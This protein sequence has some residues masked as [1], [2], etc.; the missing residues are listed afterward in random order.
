MGQAGQD[1][2]KEHFDWRIKI[3]RMIKIYRD[4]VAQGVR[5]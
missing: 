5:P 4:I 3:E 2:V 1:R